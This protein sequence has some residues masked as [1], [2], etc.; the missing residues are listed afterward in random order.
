LAAL[1]SAGC[2]SDPP[3]PDP[4]GT[5]TATLNP[6]PAPPPPAAA[7]PLL[8]AYS[9]WPGWVAWD[10]AEK[11]GF[12]RAEGV[13]VEL[14]WLEYVPSMEHFS[15]GLVD[16]VCMT[17]G[18][19]LVVAQSGAQS[20]GIL[21]NDYSNG[22]DMIVARPG[23][24]SVKNLKGKKIGVEVGFVDHLLLLE[25]LK[26]VGLKESDVEIVNEKTNATP[27]LLASGR[28]D[29]IAAWQP[30]SGQALEQVVGSRPLFTSADVPGLIY[31]LLYVNPKSLAARR[32]DWQKVVNAWFDVVA[33]I[34]SPLTRAD[35]VRI[36]SERVALPAAKYA[37]LLDGTFLLDRAGNLEHF[38]E[39]PTLASVYG[40]SR[41]V[42][43]F[44]I[45][46]HIYKD[47]SLVETL[48]DPS[49]VR[50]SPQQRR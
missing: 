19:A 11:K 41:I 12:F 28:V 22:N 9:D 48:L 38:E 16:A 46:N 30:N 1:G 14:V 6:T 37:T 17:N 21:L 47:P 29:A 26:S 49:L 32:G 36:M 24:A 13:D 33:Y 23:L 7:A 3:K 42:D 20:T 45:A 15:R 18:D 4:A 8:V 44:N 31:D 50:S 10:I 39:G 35:A 40:S 2:K 27:A 25:A 5:T 43:G 34:Q